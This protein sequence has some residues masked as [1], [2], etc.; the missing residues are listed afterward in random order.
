MYL[1]ELIINAKHVICLDADLADWNIQF[2]N[3]IK[4]AEYIVYYNKTIYLFVHS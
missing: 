4:K 2:L 1:K 3:E